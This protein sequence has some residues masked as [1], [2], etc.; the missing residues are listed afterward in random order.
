[1]FIYEIR[2]YIAK[3]RA[4]PHIKSKGRPLIKRGR[5]FG[6][7]KLKSDILERHDTFVN[8]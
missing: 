1:M 3:S 6:A 5:P 7:S 8:H 4:R 2:L